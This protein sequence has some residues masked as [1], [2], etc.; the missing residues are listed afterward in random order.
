MCVVQG[1]VRWCC[2]RSYVDINARNNADYTALHESCAA[3]HCAVARCLIQFGADVHALSQLDGARS[4]TIRSTGK[5][6]WP[7][8]MH[9]PFFLNNSVETGPVTLIIFDTQNSLLWMHVC[10]CCII[11]NFR[12]TLVSRPNKV[13][14]KCSSARTYVRP[15]KV[16]RFLISMIFGM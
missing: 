3:G 12:S 6:Y 15:Q 4:V 16:L 14:L 8:N 1:V 10:F 13:C 2:E 5:L 9:S 7:Q 11:F